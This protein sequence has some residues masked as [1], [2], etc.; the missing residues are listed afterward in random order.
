LF[1]SGQRWHQARNTP[2]KYE[3]R[4]VL[5]CDILG[6]THAVKSESIS[7]SDI[8]GVMSELRVYIDSANVLNHP[9]SQGRYD[10]E[11]EKGYIIRPIAEHFSDCVV[12]SVEATNLGAIWL[13]EVASQLQGII[14]RRGFLSRGAITSGDLW[15]RESTVFGPAF[16]D[17]VELEKQTSL[18][19]IVISDDIWGWF[20]SSESEEDYQIAKIRESQLFAFDSDGTRR[21]DPFSELKIYAGST[22]IPAHIESLLDCW[23]KTIKSGQGHPDLKTRNKYAWVACEFKNLIEGKNR[24]ILPFKGY[25]SL[26]RRVISFQSLSS[27]A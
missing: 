1:V 15:H 18:P 27:H 7:V 6:F 14:V 3:N 2:M 12:V 26:T 10:S 5:F 23:V 11:D 9:S 22:H 13:C 25:P 24:A 8:F 21:V 17:A 19:R 20:M 16:I 4:H